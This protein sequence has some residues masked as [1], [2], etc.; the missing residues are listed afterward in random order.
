MIWCV[1]ENNTLLCWEHRVIWLV[2]VGSFCAP[3]SMQAVA[4]QH[5]QHAVCIG[6]LTLLLPAPELLFT[7]HSE[8]WQTQNSVYAGCCVCQTAACAEARAGHGLL[9]GLQ[10][11]LVPATAGL[12]LHAGVA[13]G[14]QL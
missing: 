3:S 5:C 9:H 13:V 8:A 11:A 7:R 4:L 1:Q 12:V 2:V 10:Q 6:M 14:I